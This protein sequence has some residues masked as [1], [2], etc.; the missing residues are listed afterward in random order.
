MNSET[1]KREVVRDEN[2]D[3][4][5]V[6]VVIPNY[7][8]GQYIGLCVQSILNQTYKH[9][10]IIV[11]DDGS[12]DNSI[13]LLEPYLE[14]I[15]LLRQTNSGVNAARNRGIL[16]AKGSLIALCDSDDYWEPTKLEKQVAL[17]SYQSKVVMVGCSVAYFVEEGKVFEIREA[18]STGSLRKQ[19]SRNPGVSWIPG[20]ASTGLFRK[21][22]AL[23]CGLFDENLRGNGE[24][25]EF[26]ARLSSRGDFL[27]SNE[28]LVKGRIHASSR[29]N[30]S[31]VDW[32]HDNCQAFIVFREKTHDLRLFEYLLGRTRLVVSFV[33][34]TVKRAVVRA[35]L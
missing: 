2:N 3:N 1:S 33:K 35:R 15:T 32:Y 10:E 8:Y 17:M 11:V 26:F 7:N 25:W 20:A 24:D 12:T 13:A 5:L 14:Q 16:R 4:C 22:D 6:S 23:E 28:P 9:R 34:A 29:T 18:L 31:L 21:S 30:I 27:S 19:Y